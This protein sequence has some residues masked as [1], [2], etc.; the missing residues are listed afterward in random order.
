[1]E[2]YKPY[3][4]IFFTMVEGGQIR[5][6]LRIIRHSDSGF[7]T[8]EDAKTGKLNIDNE[9]MQRFTHEAQKQIF[10]VGTIGVPKAYRTKDAGRASIWLYGAV[11]GYSRREGLPHA[12]ASFDAEYFEG[13]KG[14]F[15]DGLQQM[16]PVVDY[17]GSGTVPVYMTESTAY[18]SICSVDPTGELKRTLDLG[19]QQ[20]INA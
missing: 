15:G 10:E 5:G 20:I 16:G 17:M 2:E 14:L 8:L 4:S 19:A 3:N 11:L 12:V 18:A 13:F 6:V 7:K 1:M 9:W